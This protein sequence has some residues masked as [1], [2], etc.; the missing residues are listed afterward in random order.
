VFGQGITLT[1]TVTGSTPTGTVDFLDG[2]TPLCSAVALVATQATCTT[3]A[4]S[5]G[6]HALTAAYGGDADDGASTS[7]PL[8]QVVDPGA[9][10]TSV[11]APGPI[12]LGQSAVVTAMVAVSAPGGGTPI[13]TIGISD[14]V[15]SCSIVLPASACSL[16][17]TTGGVRTV[18]A[19]YGGDANVAASIGSTS[20]TVDPSATG[21]VLASDINPSV[22]GQG[23]TFTATVTGN[24]P[25]GTVDF[26]DGAT[27]LCSALA[28]AGAQATCTASALS[29]GAHSITAVYSGDANNVASTSAP[30]TQTVNPA[31]T[32]TSVSAPGPIALGDAVIV[33]ASVAA[34]APG[35]GT[36]TGTIGISD[37]S[38][39][40]SIALPATS[41]SLTPTSAGVKTIT[42]S[43]G[44]DANFAAS[45]A[46]AGLAVDAAAQT[47][48]VV[49]PATTALGDGPVII[50]AT[51]SSGLPISVTSST[52]AVCSVAGSGPFTVTPIAPGLCTLVAN[53]AGDADNAPASLTIDLQ[54]QGQAVIG[55]PI[56]VPALD[57]WAL[58]AAVLL[59]GMIGAVRTR[60]A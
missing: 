41:C 2:V 45:T 29:V 7:A 40:C 39:T 14:G 37:G 59:L 25:T 34:S 8:A 23:V 17:P 43:Y 54:V 22:R 49:A 15:V 4:L 53:Q 5:A 35:A 33:T 28:L 42:A 38:A 48:T 1:A 6:A 44:G 26:L 56:V 11:T 30:I 52:P 27:P 60:R 36:P 57:R 31:A 55:Q 9:T 46:Q 32:L 19:S 10:V 12:T 51:A 16:T 20:L 50:T 3:N 47:I 21:V 18:T 58:F 24:A 13:G